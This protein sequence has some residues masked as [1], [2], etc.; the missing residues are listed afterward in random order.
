MRRWVVAGLMIFGVVGLWAVQASG[1]GPDWAAWK[2]L[3]G[4]WV[5]EGGGSPGQGSG[6]FSFAPDLQGRILVRHNQAEYPA[7]GG[8]PAAVHEDLLIAYEE[9]GAVKAVYWDSEGHFIAYE[10]TVTP[11]GSIVLLS[12][13]KPGEPRYRLTYQGLGNG[14]LAILFEVAPPGKP[15]EFV[16][17]LHGTARR[18]QN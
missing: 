9:A 15:N 5:G 17:Y 11:E 16:A 2:F 10:A 3:L 1:P 7:A 8:R 18:K 13:E 14:R 6:V 12:P 4:D